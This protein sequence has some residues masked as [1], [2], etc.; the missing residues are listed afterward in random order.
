MN[1]YNVE[2]L[3]S[4]GP[5]YESARAPVGNL[6]EVLEPSTNAI[7]ISHVGT[8]VSTLEVFKTKKPHGIKLPP[9]ELA[10]CLRSV[11]AKMCDFIADTFMQI[12]SYQ[13]KIN[14]LATHFAAGTFPTE[15]ASIKVPQLTR[16]SHPTL[17][18]I[19]SFA[20]SAIHDAKLKILEKQIVHEKLYL[21]G[22]QTVMSRRV[23]AETYKSA[24][25]SAF[26][27]TFATEFDDW[28]SLSHIMVDYKIIREACSREVNTRALR[29]QEKRTKLAEAQQAAAAEDASKTV[30]EIV[31]E[32]VKQV[33]SK[34][35]KP[36]AKPK[37]PPK[38]KQKA[39]GKTKPKTTAQPSPTT[40]QTTTTVNSATGKNK[41]KKSQLK[42]S[43]TKKHLKG[44]PPKGSNSTS[45]RPKTGGKN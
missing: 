16:I 40:P 30:R 26:R 4:S 9:L 22:L 20:R 7:Y 32:Q 39:P 19:Q 43:S 38:A 27:Q 5:V 35:K 23:V 1:D 44:S 13:R 25:A 28:E 37:E 24:C 18:E 31:S 41:F 8:A 6:I 34:S 42:N 17:A 15:Y 11:R 45:S 33:M 12:P 21:S 36:N 14:R 10:P 3:F 29:E 2:D